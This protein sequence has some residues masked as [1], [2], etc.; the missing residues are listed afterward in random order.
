MYVEDPRA[1]ARG[2]EKFTRPQTDWMGTVQSIL[3]KQPAAM[4]STAAAM[5][6]LRESLVTTANAQVYSDHS[7]TA[8]L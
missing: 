2:R 8:L 5:Q 1:F 4:D 3:H 6:H 7:N